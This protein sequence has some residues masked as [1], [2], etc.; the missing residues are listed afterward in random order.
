VVDFCR[1][2]LLLVPKADDFLIWAH[3]SLPTYLIST[4]YEAY[5]MSLCDLIGFPAEHAFSTQ[6]DLDGHQLMGEE[7]ELVRRKAREI[8]EFPM[9]PEAGRAVDSETKQTVEALDRIFEV[10]STGGPGELM[11]GVEPVGG[12]EKA[13]RVSS[14]VERLQCAHEAIMYVGDSITDVDAFRVVREGG[15]LTVSFNGNRYAVENAEIAVVSRSAEVLKDIVSRFMQSSKQGVVEL[16]QRWDNS[17]WPRLLAVTS[18]NL[19][20]IT[21]ESETVR[22]DLRGEEIGT[23]G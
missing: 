18:Q 8:V 13:K 17:R 4:S 1:E 14:I 15:G 21:E 22:R 6:L 20:A 7:V 11:N 12:E 2:G 23:L 16:A 3:R 19:E 10:L 9:I 5:I